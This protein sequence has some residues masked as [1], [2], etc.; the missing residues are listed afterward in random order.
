[1]VSASGGVAAAPP[2]EVAREHERVHAI[3]VAQHEFLGDHAA[4][5]GAVH[6]G[7]LDARGVEHSD[8]VSGHSR[9]SCSGRTGSRCG[10]N[11]G[12]RT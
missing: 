1:M 5:R 9:R 10:P 12:C 8:G 4:H 3:R 2:G 7:A 6:M 11:R